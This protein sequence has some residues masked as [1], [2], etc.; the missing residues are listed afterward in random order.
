MEDEKQK[1]L[2]RCAQMHKFPDE[3]GACLLSQLENLHME[4]QKSGKETLTRLSE[5]LSRVDRLIEEVERKCQ[6]P[7]CGIL[8]DIKN[9]L[10]R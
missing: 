10:S 8:K 9:N 4:I 3:K 2:S 6:Q 1:V 5:E 7:G